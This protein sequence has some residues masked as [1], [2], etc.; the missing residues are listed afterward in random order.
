MTKLLACVSTDSSTCVD[1]L[2][3]DDDSNEIGLQFA[4]SNE[5]YFYTVNGDFNQVKS[6]LLQHSNAAECGDTT[7]SLGRYI[8]RLR[9]DNVLEPIA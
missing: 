5:V 8:N 4:S 9:N 3:F 1:Y 6:S 7:V 2:Y